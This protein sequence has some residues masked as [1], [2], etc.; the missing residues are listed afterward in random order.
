M[1]VS[2][3]QGFWCSS[4]QINKL[5][6]MHKH[7]KLSLHASRIASFLYQSSTL[8]NSLNDYTTKNILSKWLHLFTVPKLHCTS[9]WLQSIE[10]SAVSSRLDC[11]TLTLKLRYENLHKICNK[12]VFTFLKQLLYQCICWKLVLIFL[13][14]F[15][16]GLI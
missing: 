13:K 10:Q 15:L 9:K 1:K 2:W 3:A 4:S 11:S 5:I 6:S 16:H 12:N 8:H 14:K 7:C